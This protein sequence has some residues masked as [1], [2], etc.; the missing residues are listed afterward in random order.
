MLAAQSWFGVSFSDLNIASIPLSFSLEQ[1]ELEAIAKKSPKMV[2]AFLDRIQ[3][4]EEKATAAPSDYMFSVKVNFDIVKSKDAGAVPV[5][6]A[7][8]GEEADLSVAL[9]S[10]RVPEQFAWEYGD[11]KTKLA[12]RYS[13]FKANGKFNELLKA[14]KPD[15]KICHAR[16]LNP[17]KP[18]K[19][20]K[21]FYNPNIVFKLDEHY[22]RR[23]AA[24]AEINENVVVSAAMAAQ[25]PQRGSMRTVRSIGRA[26]E[27]EEGFTEGVM[28]APAG[29][30][31]ED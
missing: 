5:R 16:H 15:G 3:E 19:Q 29:E 8:S 23:E 24:A 12:E 7:R 4:I 10:N 28:P 25:D 13:D 11:L 2:L 14:L 30:M 22:T 17:N 20:P 31:K 27:M 21:Y 6:W 1:E 18:G 9:D 26:V